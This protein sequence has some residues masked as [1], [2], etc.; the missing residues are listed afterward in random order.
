[1]TEDRNFSV[2]GRTNDTFNLGGVNVNA[3]LLDFVL[4]SISGV[5]DAVCFMMPASDGLK[6]AIALIR[7]SDEAV[8]PNI[9][10]EARIQIATMSSTEATPAKFIF[11]DVIPRTEMAKPDR[12]ACVVMALARRS[13]STR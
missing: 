2:T 7:A 4:Q 1:V 12:A 11:S 10:S 9:V 8:T 3:A 6:E 13:A 5:E